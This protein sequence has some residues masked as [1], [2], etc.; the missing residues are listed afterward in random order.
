MFALRLGVNRQVKLVKNLIRNLTLNSRTPV[1]PSSLTSNPHIWRENGVLKLPTI[2]NTRLDFPNDAT[3]KPPLADPETKKQIEAPALPES[4]TPKEAVRLIVI[5]RK[6]MKKHKLKKLRKKMKFE[7]AKRRQK[8]ELKKEKA[9]QAVL[10]KQCKD[11][12]NFSAEKYVNDKLKIFYELEN[13]K[14]VGLD[15]R[16]TQNKKFTVT[17]TKKV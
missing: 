11:A 9:F 6:K 17:T 14:P 13:P 15:H 4:S 7:W 16:N 5:R 12:E 3:F 8:R 1:I 2:I 10:I